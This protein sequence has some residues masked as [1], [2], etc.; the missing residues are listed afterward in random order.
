MKT[1]KA[2]LKDLRKDLN[3]LFFIPFLFLLG[4]IVIFYSYCFVAEHE[5][6]SV[7]QKSS[8]ETQE[9]TITVTCRPVTAFTSAPYVSV[10]LNDLE[11]LTT[12][13]NAGY[14]FTG[15]CINS[16]VKNVQLIEAGKKVKIYMQDGQV[17]E[18][19]IIYYNSY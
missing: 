17:K 15:Q 7:K 4:L 1:L 11:I 6:L 14:D 2:I 5:I 3:F 8:F 9:F 19:P 16:S 10:R 18:I 12:M 13:V